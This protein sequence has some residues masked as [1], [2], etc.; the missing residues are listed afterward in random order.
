MGMWARTLLGPDYSDETEYTHTYDA[1]HVKEALGVSGREDAD[2]L[3]KRYLK[4][5]HT[6]MLPKAKYVDH[7]AN[8]ARV[9][10]SYPREPM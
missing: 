3:M 8:I 4:A 7:C 9:I 5:H 10:G 1:L 6:A 2:T